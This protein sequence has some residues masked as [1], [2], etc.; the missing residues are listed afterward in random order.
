M[1][2]YWTES[3]YLA[4]AVEIRRRLTEAKALLMF[5]EWGQWLEE[6][7]SYSQRTADRLMKVFREYG[8]KLPEASACSSNC[9]LVRNLTYSQAVILLGVPEEGRKMRYR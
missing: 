2:K 1:I 3:I 4:A 5:G 9:A 7:V 6:S 8:S